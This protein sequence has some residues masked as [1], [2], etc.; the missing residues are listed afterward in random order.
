MEFHP[1]ALIVST[2]AIAVLWYAIEHQLGVIAVVVDAL[3]A[4]GLWMLIPDRWFA[5]R[6][7]LT[8]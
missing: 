1:K 8:R 7:R 6:Q 4:G 5:K 2:A 3:L